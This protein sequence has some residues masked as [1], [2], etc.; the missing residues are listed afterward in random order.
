[1]KRL[2]IFFSLLVF[3]FWAINSFGAEKTVK[4]VTGEWEP[5]SGKNME[6]KGFVAEIVTAAFNEMGIEAQITFLPW[7]RCEYMLKK[8]TAFAAFPYLKTAEREKT[9]DFSDEVGNSNMRLFYLKTNIKQEVDW[10]TFADLKKYRIGGTLGY[11]YEKDFREAGLNVDYAATDEVSLK[12]LYEG[13]MDILA[14]DELLG[15]HY[16]K[17]LYPNDLRKFETVKKPLKVD[18]LRLLISRKY[19]DAAELKDKFNIGLSTIKTNGVLAGILK[20]YNI[21]PEIQ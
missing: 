17:K 6:G 2:V 15:W 1:M 16:I 21:K 20:K 18:K 11:W 9:F 5:Y 4:L 12:K 3:C 8:G 14:M 19:P 13:R 7:K 10:N